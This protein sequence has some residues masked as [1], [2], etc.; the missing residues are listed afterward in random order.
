MVS[1]PFPIGL[2]R[3]HR[4][5]TITTD[6]PFRFPVQLVNRPNQ[7]FRGYAGTVASGRFSRETRRCSQ[8]GLSSRVDKIVTYDGS[9]KT[10]EGGDAVTLTLTDELDIARG[11]V[12]AAPKRGRRFRISSPRM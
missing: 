7:D 4:R 10:A 8:F 1:G 3:R 11:D 9:V 2:S 5:Y 6:T 12:L